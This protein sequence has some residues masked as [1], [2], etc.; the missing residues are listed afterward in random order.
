MYSSRC[1]FV[2]HQALVLEGLRCLLASR[3]E[4]RVV[5]PDCD[6]VRSAAAGFGPDIAIIQ[7]DGASSGI[8]CGNLLREICP[9][10]RVFYLSDGTRPAFPGRSISMLSSAAEFLQVLQASADDAWDED[11]ASAD[12]L[13]GTIPSG[14]FRYL[15]GRAREV[16]GLLIRGMSMKQVGRQLGITA[17]TVA[18]HKYRVMEAN[19]LRN[20][21]DLLRF[22]AAQGLSPFDIPAASAHLREKVREAAD[23]SRV[24]S[25]SV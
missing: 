9:G 2:G 24:S 21:A 20:N 10:I 13:A 18:F 11:E 1:L 8:A 22:A 25:S 17:R 19:G 3:F 15:S 5:G 6:S 12:R 14:C 23:V 7:L 4:G 16:I